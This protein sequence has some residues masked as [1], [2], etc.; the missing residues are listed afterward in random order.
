MNVECLEGTISNFYYDIRDKKNTFFYHQY[1]TIKD[2]Y[3]HFSQNTPYKIHPTATTTSKLINTKQISELLKNL[4]L[5]DTTS[6]QLTEVTK[7]IKEIEKKI[8]TLKEPLDNELTKLVDQFIEVN[9]KL[10]K[11]KDDEEIMSDAGELCESLEKK[12]FL[13]K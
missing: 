13:E 2:K 5:T 3:E 1:Q 6:S 8:K 9:K 10:A 4:R 12:G 7:E 11:N